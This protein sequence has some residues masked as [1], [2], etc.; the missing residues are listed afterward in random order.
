M[1]EG[2]ETE[3]MVDNPEGQATLI[4]AHG[5]GAGMDHAWMET[6]TKL[7]AQ[8]G[9]RVVRFEFPYMAK[10][11]VTGKAGGP[12]PM[13]T[14]L[15]TYAGVVEAEQKRAKNNKLFVSGKSMGGRVASMLAAAQATG[16]SKEGCLEKSAA[17]KKKKA[18]VPE[19][20]D[21]VNL[22]IAGVCCLGYPFHPPGKPDTLRTAHLENMA[23]PTLIL[24]GTRDTFGTTEDVKSYQLSERVRVHWLED[25]DHSLQPRK[26]SGRTLEQNMAEA[27][28]EMDK[29]MRDLGANPISLSSSSNFATGTGSKQTAMDAW[30][31]HSVVKNKAKVKNEVEIEKIDSE[32]EIKKAIPKKE[33]Y[34]VTTKKRAT[35][36]EEAAHPVQK[37]SR[38]A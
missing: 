22:N 29:F 12:N 21:S 8:K 32:S 1:A 9:Y 25:G 24:Q 4:F 15:S 3:L 23:T 11:R 2:S 33:E 14:L 13:P 6:M 7:M 27:A 35:R 38:R 37:K 20:E 16:D 31:A 34:K 26:K 18:K 10:K 36:S 5:A 28:T 30:L 19:I 17:G